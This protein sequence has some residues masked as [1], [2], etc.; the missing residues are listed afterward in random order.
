MEV[1]R[2][3]ESTRKKVFLPVMATGFV[4]CITLF[5]GCIVQP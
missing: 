5:V 4:G 2:I 1:K 3:F